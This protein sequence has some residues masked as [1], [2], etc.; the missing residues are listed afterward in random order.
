MY[1]RVELELKVKSSN[2]R[3]QDVHL[4]E[5]TRALEQREQRKTNGKTHR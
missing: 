1:P 4:Q 3:R 2:D 5:L